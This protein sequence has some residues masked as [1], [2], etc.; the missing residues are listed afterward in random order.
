MKNVLLIGDSIRIGY[1]KAVKKSLE[2]IA[3]VF[4]PG[5]NCRFASY[6][7][8][9][10]HEYRALV[11]DGEVDVLHFNTGLWDCLRLFEEDPHTPIEVYAYYME[12]V[13]IRIKK[14]FPNAKVIF[15]TSTSVQSEKM[16]KNFKRYNEE[17]EE[18]NKVAVDIV[19]KH[20]FIVND[21]YA[22]SKALPEEAHSDAVHYYTSIGT[23]AFTKQVLIYLSDALELS[24]VPKYKE[25]VNTDSPIG[26]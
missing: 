18:Y 10:L 19:K 8:R 12:R 6:V 17:I 13:C 5:E 2:G 24:E 1:D 15:A 3:N 26:I 22:L 21:L 16:G 9:Y 14:F 25:V 20:G 7:L 4:Y 23:E 11:K